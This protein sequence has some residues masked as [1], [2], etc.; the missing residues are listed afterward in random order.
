[1]RF[2][3]RLRVNASLNLISAFDVQVRGHSVPRHLSC[4]PLRIEFLGMGVYKNT[5]VLVDY[6]QDAPQLHVDAS[7][8]ALNC[9]RCS[10]RV[11]SDWF[12]RFKISAGC[13]H[14]DLPWARSLSDSKLTRS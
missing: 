5:S 10:T 14:L 6:H 2:P 1:M 9:W 13:R 12:H 7:S 4:Y 11:V 3:T 8:K